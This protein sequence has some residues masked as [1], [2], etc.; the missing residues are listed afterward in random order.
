M[1]ALLARLRYAWVT[2]DGLL[3]LL[4]AFSSSIVTWFALD[5]KGSR[6]DAPFEYWGDALATGAHVKT[7]LETG[8]YEHQALLGAPWGQAYNDF[9]QADNLHLVVVKILGLFTDQWPV[10]L[11]VYF[12][13][14]FPLAALAAVWFFRTLGV[15]RLL[16]MALSIAFSIAPYHF[17]RGEGHLWLG[18]Y[19][20]I[21]L[22]F[23]LLYLL[24][25]RQPLWGRGRAS[26]GL[27]AWLLSPTSRT[28]VFVS[29]LAMSGS[30][31]GVFFIVVL[32]FT[33]IAVLIRDR[34]WRRFWGAVGA[35]IVC[36]LVM[37]ANMLP[38]LIYTWLNG[39]NPGSLQRSAPESE[40]YA[41]KLTQLLMPWPD[42]RIGFL[43][44]VRALYDQKYPLLSE[45]PALGAL[46]ALGLT[47]AFLLIAY[48]A[49]GWR[50]MA[51]RSETTQRV[52]QR[53]GWLSGLIF[54]AFLFSTVGGLSTVISFVTDAL[55]GW[56]RMSIVILILCLGVVGIFL[57]AMVRLIVHRFSWRVAPQAVMAALLSVLIVL[58]AY[59]DQ[60]PADMRA[61]RTAAASAFDAD[62]K[63]I[64]TI[65]AA[66]PQRHP[67]VLQ[68]PYIPFPES[69][70]VTGVLGS[71]ELIPY[72]QSSDIAWSGGGIKGRP[73]TDYPLALQQY[74]PADVALLAAT[75]GFNG[76]L[77]DR[78][79]MPDHSKPLEEGLTATLGAKPLVSASGRYV[80]FTL[81]EL[82]RRIGSEVGP[83][84]RSKVSRLVTDPVTAYPSSD[85]FSAAGGTDGYSE[86]TTAIPRSTISLLN[87]TATP[88]EVDISLSVGSPVPSSVRVIFGAEDVT[89]TTT[90][91]GAPVTLRVTV[92]SGAHDLKVED[93]VG[94]TVTLR[95]I[96][97]VP[98]D[99]LS[100]SR[101]LQTEG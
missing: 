86:F 18:S 42:H 60:T 25:A 12:I 90:A 32:F 28:I 70:S 34:Q 94:A 79:A 15:S 43:K 8:W 46:G 88:I 22:G 71:E 76:I 93:P 49:F 30:Y 58:V 47:L 29:I 3:Y 84:E 17:M 27:M 89:R 66:L 100:Y 53:I 101:T 92:P 81:D 39:P 13:L 10:A 97:I 73:K 56:N 85:D 99:L 50:D 69:S 57:D 80:F 16:T 23:G 45:N 65:R 14:G 24:L 35:G 87:P 51:K 44:E 48:L 83:R 64:S 98:V 54:V 96:R 67:V 68:L 40:I 72:L 75:A 41:L 62:Q 38:D 11:N 21:P 77:L 26:N 78:N 37:L 36:I 9:P 4:T 61:A 33:G 63:W 5:L 20:G 82:S 19:Y 7:T 1:R 91:E 6:L 52:V 2:S 31:Y 59:I 55:R 74:K 95:H